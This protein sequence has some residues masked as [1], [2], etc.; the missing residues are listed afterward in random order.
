MPI[1]SL[2]SIFNPSPAE[3]EAR[4]RRELLWK[5]QMANEQPW[6]EQR[7]AEPNALFGLRQALGGVMSPLDNALNIQGPFWDSIR[8][9]RDELGKSLRYA[10]STPNSRAAKAAP[11]PAVSSNAAP[12]A[13]ATGGAGSSSAGPLPFTRQSLTQ[14]ASWAQNRGAKITSMDR[15]KQHNADVGGVANSFHTRGLAFDSVPP[16]GTSMGAWK[17]ELSGRMPGWDV[18]NEGDHV[19]VEPGSGGTKANPLAGAFASAGFTPPPAFHGEGYQQADQ[20]LQAAQGL[21]MQPFSATYKTTPEPTMP[22]PTPFAPPDFSA[23]DKAFAEAAPKNPFGAT[24]EDVEKAKLKVR[25]SEY[26]AGIGQ[27][28]ASYHGGMGIG[29][30]FAKLGGGALMGAKVGDRLVE[31]KTE[32]FDKAMQQYNM[33][34]A[35]RDDGKARAMA[36]VA[37]QN[38]AQLNGYKTQLWQQ[39]VRDWQRFEPRVENGVLT[40]FD[41]DENGNVRQ[42]MTPIDPA[43]QT[44]IM[45]SRANTAIGAANA[46][47]EYDWNV[48]RFNT[49]LAGLALPYAMADAGNPQQR[50]GIAAVGLAEAA[51]AMVESG[52]WGDLYA[53][54]NMGSRAEQVKVEAMV[55]AGVQ[56]DDKG[57]I[58]STE[59]ITNEQRE[60]MNNF[61]SN[62]MIQDF[63]NSKH[64]QMLI[65]GWAQ[66]FQGGKPISK[67]F[68]ADPDPLVTISVGQS[69]H[70]RQTRNTRTDY[71]GRTTTSISESGD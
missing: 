21:T 41:K 24:P 28:L 30:L 47:S 62:A 23:G 22:E 40:T 33:A 63:V 46:A 61:I 4:R 44:G 1:S 50:D 11:A 53:A 17:A 52:R 35:N 67:P 13:P 60:I 54:A 37:N 25:R 27:M 14:M 59:K 12:S 42:T 18:I 29:E 8:G 49:T 69:R 32:A 58:L 36:E 26:F 43:R 7:G 55:Q 39:Q 5:Q 64:T 57:K 45:I 3:Q 51:D 65:G 20:L 71:R 56:M 38:I 70:R 6:N 2:F 66:S 9:T 31:E 34:L 48:H 16:K 15:S 10:F 19:H 68:K